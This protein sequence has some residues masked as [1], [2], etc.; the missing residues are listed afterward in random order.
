M[1]SEMRSY[2]LKKRAET[3]AA[4]RERIVE[5]T[6][7]LHE[8]VGPARTTVAAIAARAGVSRPTVYNQF[9]DDLSLLSA[10]SALFRGLN[11]APAL[12][13]LSLED[14]FL[15]QYGFYA[16]NDQM[17]AHIWRDA[18]VLPALAAVFEPVRRQLRVAA[19]ELVRPLGRRGARSTRA[20]AFATLAFELPTWKSLRRSGLDDVA[21]ARLMAALVREV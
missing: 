5:A 18:E 10:C 16:A 13:G 2:E 14:A 3:V 19:K 1:S 9:P 8:E 6:M 15:A 4:T 7:K 12:A 17:L 20:I 11:P 21:A